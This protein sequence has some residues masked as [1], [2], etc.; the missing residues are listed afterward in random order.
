MMQ[1]VDYAVVPDTKS[2]PPRVP[3]TLLSAMLGG[4]LVAG[5]ILGR[6]SWGRLSNN[7]EALMKPELS[8]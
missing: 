7:L 2:G 8:Q 6:A 3:L 5:W 1:V 4:L